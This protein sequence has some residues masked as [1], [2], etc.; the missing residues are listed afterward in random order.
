MA[1]HSKWKQIKRKKAVTDSKRGAVFTKL[2]KEITVAARFGG[3]DPGGNPRLRTAIDAAKAENMP[4]DNIDRAI[5][6]GTGQLEGVVY[7]EVTY[8]GYGPGGAA[9]LVQVTTDNQ[10]RTVAE[11]RHIFSRH[12]GNLG[13]PNSVAWMFERKGQLTLDAARVDE[14]AALEA[15]LDAGADDMTRDGDQFVITTTPANLHAVQ[16]ALV[17]RGLK[18]SSAEFAMI[19]K[20]TVRVEG[21]DAERLLTLMEALEEHDDVAKVFSNFDIDA[22]TLAAVGG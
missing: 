3:G 16:D 10:N 9:I 11:I 5:K 6:K 20:S 8:E 18:P 4:A 21:K 17:K 13:N 15:A 7:E 1:G 22:E 12:G 14:D 19:P 2:I